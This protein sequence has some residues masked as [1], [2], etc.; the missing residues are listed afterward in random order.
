MARLIKD[1]K[2][3]DC[4]Y[5]RIPEDEECKKALYKYAELNGLDVSTVPIGYERVRVVLVPASQ[6]I[7][8]TIFRADDRE[9]KARTSD[10]D[11]LT[12]MEEAME[13][14]GDAS[15]EMS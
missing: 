12:S 1:S 4:T 10:K 3:R 9:Q 14:A 13:K 5:I 7:H 8:D 15:C 11:R 6:E 2:D